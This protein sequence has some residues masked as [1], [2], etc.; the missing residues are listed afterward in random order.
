MK[1]SPR[2]ADAEPIEIVLAGALALEAARTLTPNPED[3]AAVMETLGPIQRWLQDWSD[4]ADLEARMV[5]IRHLLAARPVPGRR[6]RPPPPDPA[7]FVTDAETARLAITVPL[8]RPR[9]D[10]VAMPARLVGAV[11]NLILAAVFSPAQ[12]APEGR[13]RLITEAARYGG[14]GGPALPPGEYDE[15]LR[16][17]FAGDPR[18]DM[19]MAGSEDARYGEV[20]P[21]AP[22][23]QDAPDALPAEA[24]RLA[25]EFLDDPGR[26]PGPFGPDGDPVAAGPEDAR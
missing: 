14:V 23:R 2:M 4:A 25:G 9:Y 1:E 10:G 6:R 19:V 11:R 7:R 15:V 18:G 21:A 26:R 17:L 24:T 12:G 5:A 3:S 22:G 8:T 13:S 16:L 20:G